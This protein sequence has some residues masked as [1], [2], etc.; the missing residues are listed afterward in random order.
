MG[1]TLLHLGDFP[2][3][4]AAADAAADLAEYAAVAGR[5]RDDR[6]RSAR[7]APA[8]GLAELRRGL[9]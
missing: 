6:L 5:V 1:G 9:R 2:T 7:L 3:A 8:D 4:G